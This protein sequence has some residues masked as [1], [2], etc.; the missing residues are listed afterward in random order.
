MGFNST[1]KSFSAALFELYS[2]YEFMEKLNMEKKLQIAKSHKQTGL[3]G[4]ARILFVF[5]II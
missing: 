1:T 5:G 4:Q 2:K 3:C